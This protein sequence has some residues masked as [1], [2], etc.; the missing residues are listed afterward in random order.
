M[1]VKDQK[2]KKE[3]EKKKKKTKKAENERNKR[4]EKSCSKIIKEKK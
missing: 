4:I 2:L 3:E 1:K